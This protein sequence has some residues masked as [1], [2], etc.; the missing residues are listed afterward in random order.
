MLAI[1]TS[2]AIRS[3]NARTAVDCYRA[4]ERTAL[5]LP[6]EHQV[7]L[8]RALTRELSWSDGVDGIETGLDRIEMD[9][10]DE[11]HRANGYSVGEAA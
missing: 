6:A 4:L 2:E 8:M 5:L 1:T 9:L 11:N 3:A 10:R 7:R